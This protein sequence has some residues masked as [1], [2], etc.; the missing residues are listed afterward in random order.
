MSD[1]PHATLTGWTFSHGARGTT[2]DAHVELPDGTTGAVAINMK[3]H[4]ALALGFQMLISVWAGGG[5]GKETNED[6]QQ[7]NDLV[8]SLIRQTLEQADE[9]GALK[10]EPFA[11]HMRALFID[12]GCLF[13]DEA[14]STDGEV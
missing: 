6:I 10:A 3:S 5:S 7:W 9:K 1:R 12:I 8:V 4:Q 13:V 14:L 2:L 11:K